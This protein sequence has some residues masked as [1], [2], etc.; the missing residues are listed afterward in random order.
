MKH[1]CASL[2]AFIFT[3]SLFAKERPNIILIM[4]DDQGWGQTGYYNHP[5]L[6][7]PNL[8]KMAENGLRFDRFY[9]G[10]PVCSP[11][12]ASVLTGRACVRSGVPTHGYALRLQE[13]V[14]PKA[15]QEAGYTTGHF[16]KWH[17]N[18]LRGPGAPVFDS[19]S[20]SPGVF[21][22]D[23]WLTVTNFFDINP[24]MS[25][26][27]NFE[28]FEG[29]SSEIIVNEALAFI[30]KAVE[31]QETFF[32]VIWDGS[33]HDPFVA[34]VKDMKGFEHLNT[35]SR[36]HYGEIVAFDRSLGKLRK[37]LRELKVEENTILWFCS[38]NGGLPKIEPETV[39]GLR[40]NK[41]TIW[42]GGIRVPGI[43]EWPGHIKPNITSYPASTMDIFPTLADLLD[44]PKNKLLQP[45][46]GLS[47]KPHI[48]NKKTKKRKNP[49]PFMYKGQGA[50]IDNEYKLVV[51]SLEKQT[52]QLFNLV[53]DKTESKDIAKEN[54]KK[55]KELKSKYLQW[56]KSA[57]KSI[58]GLDYPEKKVNDGQPV[59]RFWMDDAKY[60]EFKKE[61]GNRPEYSGEYRKMN[62][63]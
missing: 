37:R 7:T 39:G 30:E 14:L 4:T 10:A 38:D 55:F 51:T 42:E 40:G 49:I 34:N 16:G 62:N 60:E 12:R 27:G 31:N 43:I 2:L 9:A 48:L 11:T 45:V 46:D 33:P 28:E 53:E 25:R 59:R 56:L 58:Q 24:I 26:N 32:T 17:L 13:K 63:K 20:H 22:F 6:K 29:T 44:L 57:E 21:G 41:G 5:I 19:D 61:H 23:Y 35:A 18:G 50:L 15:L 47:L 52:F 8:D 54:P 36:H 1:L 3:F